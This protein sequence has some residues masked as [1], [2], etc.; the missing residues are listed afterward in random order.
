MPS[1]AADQRD[2]ILARI[3]ERTAHINDERREG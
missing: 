1:L 3:G 2:R